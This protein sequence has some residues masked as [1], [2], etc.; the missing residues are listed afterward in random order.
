MVRLHRWADAEPVLDAAVARF[1]D[2]MVRHRCTA[3]LDRAEARMGSR[4]VDAACVDAAE[5]LA[6]AAEVQDAQNLTRLEVL[7]RRAADTGAACGVALR[8]EMVM[9]KADLAGVLTIR[10]ER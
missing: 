10:D 5:S 8:R 6:L 1:G 2:D 9:V 7:S 4:D 3:L